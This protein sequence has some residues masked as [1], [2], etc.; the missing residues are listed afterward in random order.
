MQF[1]L[2]CCKE[3]SEDCI[4]CP[5]CGERIIED[6]ESGTSN[7]K[8]ELKTAIR[9]SLTVERIREETKEKKSKEKIYRIIGLVLCIGGLLG[10]PLITFLGIPPIIMGII[11]LLV[12]A[13]Y[14]GQA[15]KLKKLL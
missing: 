6:A 7:D 1:C 4:F 14:E 5:K 9:D 15:K 8:I 12:S 13:D 11:L 10:I 2:Q 3:I